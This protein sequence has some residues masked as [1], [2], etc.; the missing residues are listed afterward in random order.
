MKK[1]TK[2]ELTFEANPPEPFFE[3]DVFS[4][5]LSKDCTA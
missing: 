4:N 5:C 3:S 2:I 1:K